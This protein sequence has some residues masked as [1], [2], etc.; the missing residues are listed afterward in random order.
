MLTMAEFDD[1]D[2]DCVFYSSN[3][4]KFGNDKDTNLNNKIK[5]SKNTIDICKLS[6]N[7]YVYPHLCIDR[8]LNYKEMMEIIVE[9]KAKLFPALQIFDDDDYCYEVNGKWN[10]CI[11]IPYNQK[12]YTYM[13]RYDSKLEKI[14]LC[15]FENI[16]YTEIGHFLLSKDKCEKLYCSIEDF[17]IK[18]YSA[19]KII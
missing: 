7:V 3:S 1:P 11:G 4:E 17:F 6:N 14:F 10:I 5:K 19:Y 9:L 12:L 15:P 16:Q 2:D 13:I 18:K 8:K